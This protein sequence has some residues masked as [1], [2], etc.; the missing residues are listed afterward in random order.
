MKK[1]IYYLYNYIIIIE[2]YDFQTNINNLNFCVLL[3]KLINVYLNDIV[4]VKDNINLKSKFDSE[5]SYNL[6]E[7]IN[8]FYNFYDNV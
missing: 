5:L 6:T 2:I 4:S 7:S 8:S 1:I 3:N